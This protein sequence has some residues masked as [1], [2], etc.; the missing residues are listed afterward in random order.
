MNVVAELQIQF[1]NLQYSKRFVTF[2][3]LLSNYAGLDNSKAFTLQASQLPTVSTVS[4]QISVLP[5]QTSQVSQ[6]NQS[7]IT[8]VAVGV[9]VGAV[10]TIGVVVALVMYRSK[11]SKKNEN[12]IMDALPPNPVVS[13]E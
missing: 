13:V 4:T 5:T 3:T 12:L 1:A 2:S 8:N 9:A 6:P 10:F 7:P 11:I